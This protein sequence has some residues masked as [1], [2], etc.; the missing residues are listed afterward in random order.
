MQYFASSYKLNKVIVIGGFL[1]NSKPI[2]FFLTAFADVTFIDIN[3]LNGI[4]S[5]DDIVDNIYQQINF[6]ISN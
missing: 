2:D 4:A 5:I 3:L 6:F 1:F